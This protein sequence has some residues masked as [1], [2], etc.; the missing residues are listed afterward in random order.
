MPAHAKRT[1]DMT[2]AMNIAKLSTFLA[3]CVSEQRVH[4]VAA[5]APL[6]S[7]GTS[8]S[9]KHWPCAISGALAPTT[10]SVTTNRIAY[11][12]TATMSKIVTRQKMGHTDEVR[13][14]G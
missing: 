12:R 3:S 9:G 14:G 4:C 1:A 7:S 5:S 11:R 2:I 10:M 8:G 13:V 6:H